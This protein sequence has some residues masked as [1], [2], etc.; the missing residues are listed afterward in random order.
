MR[1][2]CRRLA[3][4]QGTVSIPVPDFGIWFPDFGIWSRGGLGE[5]Y[6][7]HIGAILKTSPLGNPTSP[8]RNVGT[9]FSPP[10]A[11][12]PFSGVVSDVGPIVVRGGSRSFA[13]YSQQNPL[14]V[15][16]LH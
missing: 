7:A 8:P 10:N 13:V 9:W 4:L 1:C 2:P 16:L 15:R 11:L 14:S 3:F 6:S 5:G 12:A